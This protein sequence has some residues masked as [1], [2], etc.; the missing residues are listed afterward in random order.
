MQVNNGAPLNDNIERSRLIEELKWEPNWNL[1][2]WKSFGWAAVGAIAGGGYAARKGRNIP[3]HMTAFASYG[4]LCSLSYFLS[5]EYFFGREIE[6][7][8]QEAKSL[9]LS[10]YVANSYPWMW[11]VPCGAAAGIIWTG[12][13][14][15]PAS[16]IVAASIALGAAAP[17]IRLS[18][19]T[20]VNFLMP[21]LLPTESQILEIEERRSVQ[22]ESQIEHWKKQSAIRQNDYS[23]SWW[24][25]VPTWF[26]IRK[27]SI[28][29]VEAVKSQE[30][31]IKFLEDEVE[32]L[33]VE[34][35]IRK[36]VKQLEEEGARNNIGL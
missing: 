16:T 7:Y 11:D 34:V 24:R 20:T 10:N 26:P 21:Y 30:E 2:V 19:S 14:A 9:G 36:R 12:L 31:R 3:A 13:A 29:E 1:C 6:R 15:R 4:L 32:R 28:E 27:I 22:S 23:Q 35:G 5:R 18:T 33:S 25:F 17:I 8:K